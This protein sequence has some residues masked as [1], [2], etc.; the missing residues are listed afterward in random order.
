[1]LAKVNAFTQEGK[2]AVLLDAAAIFESKIDKLCAFTAV[3]S[4]PA[5]IRLDRIMFRDSITREKAIHRMGAQLS[6]EEYAKKADVVLYNYA[7]Y[8][9]DAE[10]V[11]IIDKYKEKIL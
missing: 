1:A 3:V 6:D 8:D 5:E 10:I 7:P 2:T 4:A 9:T 11:K